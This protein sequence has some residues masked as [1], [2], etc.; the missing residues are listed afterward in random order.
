MTLDEVL[1]HNPLC[2][3]GTGPLTV[4]S[5]RDALHTLRTFNVKPSLL[6][7]SPQDEET[8]KDVIASPPGA[9]PVREP[10]FRVIADARFGHGIWCVL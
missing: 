8:A 4:Y 3:L 9:Q 7:V 5:L 6:V 2:A 1:S 10:L